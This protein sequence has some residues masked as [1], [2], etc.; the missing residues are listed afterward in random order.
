MVGMFCDCSKLTELD[1]SGFD[2]SNVTIM[3]FMFQYC[4]SLTE[5]DVSGFDTAKV[6]LMNGMNGMFQGC[7]RLT[8]LSC[9]DSRILT[10][11]NHRYL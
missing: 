9:S 7:G 3:S 6:I 5:L 11:Y 1:L 2:T 10:E 4:S 8:D